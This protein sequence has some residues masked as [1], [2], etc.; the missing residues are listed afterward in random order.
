[1][2]NVEHTP[3]MLIFFVEQSLVPRKGVEL[4][5]RTISIR[6]ISSVPMVGPGMEDRLA[7]AV[8]GAGETLVELRR[9]PMLGETSPPG[10]VEL[11]R[12]WAC[13]ILWV[14]R[15]SNG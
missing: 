2:L 12:S 14:G 4:N 11:G 3:D 6:T 5:C 9:S 15:D 7:A 8:L 10:V 13:M 1:M